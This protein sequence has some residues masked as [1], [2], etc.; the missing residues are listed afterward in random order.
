MRRERVAVIALFALILG[1]FGIAVADTSPEDAAKYRQSLMKALSG[2]N[3]MLSLTVRG[4]A[5]NPDNV[6]SHADALATLSAEVAAAFEGGG[7]FE[8]SEALAAIWEQPEAFAQAVA[9]FD[10]AVAALGDVAD[11]GDMQAIDG[12]H[13]EVGKACKGCHED[14]RQKD[15]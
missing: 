13:R 8:D 2:H 1:S 11:S 14:F 15:D 4:K 9:D 7:T 3:G 5:G 12:A 6:V 10:A